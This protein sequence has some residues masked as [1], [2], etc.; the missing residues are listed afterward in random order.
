LSKIFFFIWI[1]NIF[2][3]IKKLCIILSL[4][5]KKSISLYKSKI[6]RNYEI[7][8]IFWDLLSI[9]DKNYLLILSF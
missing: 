5:V 2:I 1:Y 3:P 6:N 4:F 7:I 8:Q 9:S